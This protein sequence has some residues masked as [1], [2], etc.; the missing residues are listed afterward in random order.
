[1]SC[2]APDAREVFVA[3]SFN[4]WNPRAMPLIGDGD[5]TWE[6]ELPLLPGRYE[7]KF[8][9]DGAWCCEPG[10]DD[11]L[12]DVPDLVVNAFGT[13]NRVVDVT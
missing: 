1:L 2:F 10:K 13:R 3:G 5:G 9:I 6:L 4:D 12:C 8:V 11:G 7:F